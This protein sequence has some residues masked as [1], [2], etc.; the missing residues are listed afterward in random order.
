MLIITDCPI[1][2]LEK[3][4]KSFNINIEKTINLEPGCEKKIN[5]NTKECL[6]LIT[7]SVYKNFENRK[8]K[9]EDIKKEFL[10]I[11]N[12]IYKIINK[13]SFLGA[14]VYIPLVPKHFI[15]SDRFYNF[16]L[17]SESKNIIINEINNCLFFEFKSFNNVFFLRGLENLSSEICKNYFR[18]GSIYDKNNS[19]IILDQIKE[20]KR[21]FEKKNK[22]LI[23]FDLDNTIWKG[24]LGDDLIEGISIDNQDPVGAVFRCVQNIFLEFKSRGFLLAICSKNNEEIALEALFNKNKSI[25]KRSDIVSW[26]INW[27]NKSENIFKICNELNISLLETIFIDDSEYECDE[28]SKNCKGISIFKVPKDIYKYPFLLSKSDLFHLNNLSKIDKNR[29][30]MYKENI[31]RKNLYSEAMNNN[32]SKENWI[33]SLNLKL[34]LED[35]KINDKFIPRIIQLFNRTN[36]F[37]L[38]YNKY[39]IS[40]FYN[41]LRNK[42][43]IYYCGSTMDRIGNEGIISVIGF[44]YNNDL[45]EVNDYILSCRVF[46]KYIEESMLIPIIDLALR[47]KLFIIFNFKSNGRNKYINEFLCSYTS[48]TYK[49]NSHDLNN[50][51]N[52]FNKLPVKLIDNTTIRL[53]T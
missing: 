51:K 3:T 43:Q 29:T 27:S 41:N 20:H 9:Y 52:K 22:K 32:F 21:I 13:L 37:N 18:F 31:L 34:T 1:F 47:N 4:A 39:N 35:I 25:F 50:L 26:K 53:L 45:I 5:E 38:N 16:F 42:N 49:L 19:F 12:Y 17:D 2:L 36:Q 24:I 28:V 8:N 48:K 33:R 7:E 40:S 15:Y 14:K 6:L 30:K 44:K 46:G 11:K 23:I 10:I